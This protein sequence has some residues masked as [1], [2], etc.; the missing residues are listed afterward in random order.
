MT[1]RLNRRF[2]AFL[3]LGRP[4]LE[5]GMQGMQ[6]IATSSTAENQALS[7]SLY[8]HSIPN[9]DD[10]EDIV[11]M[12]TNAARATARVVQNTARVM[13]VQAIALAQ[14]VEIAGTLEGLAPHGREFVQRLRMTLPAIGAQA[15]NGAVDIVKDALFI[16]PLA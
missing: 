16:P 12:G 9:N 7:T 6:Y 15:L 1:D 14:A 2:P 4:G 5:Y 3:S 10:N 13:A 11:S 8:V